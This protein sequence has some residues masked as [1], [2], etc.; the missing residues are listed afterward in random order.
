MKRH[1][2]I[3]TSLTAL[4]IA[5]AGAWTTQHQQPEQAPSA[6]PAPKQVNTAELADLRLAPESPD[7]G[8]KRSEFGDWRSTGNGCNT[9]A[10]I[11]QNTGQNVRTTGRC[12]VTTGS[13]YS[14]YDGK[15]ASSANQLDIDHL[16]PLQEAYRSGADNWSRQQR[17]DYANDPLVLIP[18]SKSSNRS[19]GDRDPDSWRPSDHSS[20][21]SNAKRWITI[22]ERYRLSA[23][24]REES[25]LADMLRTCQ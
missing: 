18:V 1:K 21:C 19:K 14:A 8:Y 15:P 13:W 17:E 20:W 12:T 10:T 6:S 7:E 5:A 11:L 22:K 9:R 24:K 16:V 3:V 25:A 2:K 23:D 4:A